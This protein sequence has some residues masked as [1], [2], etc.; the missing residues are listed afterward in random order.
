MSKYKKK[1]NCSSFV[2]HFVHYINCTVDNVLYM[3]CLHLKNNYFYVIKF[4]VK[5]FI[6]T[7][8]YD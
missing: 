4:N 3:F 8:V 1:K 2:P 5:I 7:Y 6:V